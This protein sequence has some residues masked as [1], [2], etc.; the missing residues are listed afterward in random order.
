MSYVVMATGGILEIP[1]WV[2]SRWPDGSRSLVCLEE[3]AAVF[4][5]SHEATAAI[6]DIPHVLRDAT[7]FS[8]EPTAE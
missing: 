2:S 8:V 3:L 1:T 7:H 6:A 4:Q 5:T